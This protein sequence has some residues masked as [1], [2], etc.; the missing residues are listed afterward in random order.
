MIF[1]ARQIQEKSVE[2]SQDLYLTFVDLK[3]S[4]P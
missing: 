4:T 3:L 1:S 2:Q